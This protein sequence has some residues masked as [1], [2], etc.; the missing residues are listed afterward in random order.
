VVASYVGVAH[1]ARLDPER[2]WGRVRWLGFDMPKV[3]ER[4]VAGSSYPELPIWGAFE[5]LE[6]LSHAARTGL[7]LAMLPT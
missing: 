3:T 7:G 2:G 4:L 5:S 1:A 6:L